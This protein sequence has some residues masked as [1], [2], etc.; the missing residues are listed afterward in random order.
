MRKFESS[1]KDE[2][3]KQSVGSSKAENLEFSTVKRRL[4]RPHSTS[5]MQQTRIV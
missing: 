4:S 1:Q 5:T 2:S 3:K